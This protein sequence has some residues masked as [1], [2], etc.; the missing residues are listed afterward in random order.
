MSSSKQ[1]L[2]IYL[3]DH[4]AGAAYALDLVGS[5]RDNFRVQE[6]GEFAA[7]LFAEIAADKEVLYSVASRLGPSSDILKD[8]VAWL[9]EKVSR[10]KIAHNDPTG[11]GLF[12]VLEFLT[13]GIQGKAAL[14]RALAEVREQHDELA[15]IDFAKLLK[16]AEEQEQAVEKFR[17]AAAR[18]AFGSS[19]R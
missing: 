14:W 19:S 7:M 4:L 16:R 13:L 2:A 1:S 18:N 17:L 9:T 8:S 6:L 10:F 12:E 3:H 5:M 11:L 15:R